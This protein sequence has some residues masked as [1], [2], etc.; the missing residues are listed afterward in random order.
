MRIKHTLIFVDI[1]DNSLTKQVFAK[2]YDV[3]GP[4]GY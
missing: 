1:V 3:S 2:F 4:H